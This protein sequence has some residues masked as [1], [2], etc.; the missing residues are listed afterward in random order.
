[1]LDHARLEPLVHG[2]NKRVVLQ[3]HLLVESHHVS[4][5]LLVHVCSEEVVEDAE[6]TTLVDRDP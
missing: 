6:R 1:V 4:R 5:R 3:P 2:F